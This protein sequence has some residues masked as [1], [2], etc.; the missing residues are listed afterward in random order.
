MS[1][2]TYH[3]GDL[4][5][6]LLSGAVERVRRVGAEKV[7]LRAIAGDLG[8]SPSAA[9]HHF[10]DKDAL[11]TAAG[12]TAID[13]LADQQEVALSLITATGA[14]GALA[15]FRA[16]GRSYVDFALNE[17]HLFR[18]AFGGHCVIPNGIQVG[19]H[20]EEQPR[21]WVILTTTLDG[22]VGAGLLKPEFRQKSEILVWSAV[23]GVA[24]LILEGQLPLEAADELFDSLAQL[25][26]V[27]QL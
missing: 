1:K 14:D 3:H 12:F 21:A 2:A 4:E 9:Y 17:P 8:V 19:N 25:L 11:L 16:L 6:A 23:H 24:T 26:G 18:L 27:R 10:P 20:G 5:S 15:R 13:K 7:S 22:L